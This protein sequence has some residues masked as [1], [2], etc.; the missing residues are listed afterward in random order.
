MDQRRSDMRQI[1]A[2]S[3]AEF[4]RAAF[5]LYQ[6]LAQRRFKVLDLL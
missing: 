4:Q 5:V 3:P 2:P 1:G 6:I